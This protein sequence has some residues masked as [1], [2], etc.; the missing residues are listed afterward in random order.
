MILCLDVGASRMKWGLAGPNGWVQQGVVGNAD[1]GTLILRDWQAMPRPSRVVGANTAGE[2]QRVRI[3]GQLARWRAN[4]EWIRPRAE[5]GGVVNEYAKPATLGADR[6]AALVAAYRRTR[7]R[8]PDGA[9]AVVIDAGT[10]ITVDALTA[11]GHFRGG[12]LLPGL[13][14]MLGA[15]AEAAPTAR[16]AGGA[17]RE[18]PQ[19]DADGAMTGV[20]DAACGAIEHLRTRADPAPGAVRCYLAGGAAREIAPHLAAPVELVDNLVLEG[21]LALA[22]S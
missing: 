13:Q 12:L 2:A 15:L 11:D 5:G 14:A 4:I 19:T 3:E 7:R 9:P 8:H 21:V 10:S 20:I 22:G 1:I 16:L 17:W 18:W 6:W